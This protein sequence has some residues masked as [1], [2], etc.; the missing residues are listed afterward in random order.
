MLGNGFG[1][2]ITNTTKVLSGSGG[3]MVVYDFN[4]DG[5]KDVVVVQQ[6]TNSIHQLLGNGTGGF[7]ATTYTTAVGN[8][9]IDIV[10]ADLNNDA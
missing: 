3:R 4:T 5:N 9:P 1:N 10:C 8:S 2:F 6:S 7:M